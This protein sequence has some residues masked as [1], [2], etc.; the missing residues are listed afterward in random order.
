[1][2]TN[3]GQ[4]FWEK[5]KYPHLSISAQRQ[6]V[7]I[8]ELELPYDPAAALIPLPDI[9]TITPPTANLW[10]TINQRSTLRSYSPQAL[11]L[12]ELALLLWVTQGVKEVTSRPVT[13]RTVPSAGSRHAFESFLL[14]NRVEGLTPAIYRYLALEHALLPYDLSADS[15]DRIQTACWNQTHISQSV[16]T[17]IWAAQAE[18]MTWRYCERG[19]RYL[20]LDAGHVCQNLYLA[21]E[22]LGW[23]VCAIAAYDDDLLNQA[24]KLDGEQ[25]F[26]VYAATL[27]KP[28]MQDK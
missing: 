27:G 4:E 22:G 3:I 24:L 25:V 21:A 26:V 23:G 16:V 20:L 19:Y 8:P 28:T 9:S 17:F 1:M 12:E 6:G 10:A 5:T 13:F 14:I 15:C 11:T 2:A 18:R 7:P